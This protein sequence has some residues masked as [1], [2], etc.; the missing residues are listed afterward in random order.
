MVFCDSFAFPQKK[1]R[2]YTEKRLKDIIKLDMWI[3][4]EEHINFAQASD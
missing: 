3:P 2:G 1:T 4:V